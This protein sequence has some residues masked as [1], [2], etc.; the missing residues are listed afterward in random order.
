VNTASSEHQP[1]KEVIM[2]RKLDNI[3]KAFAIVAH[4]PISAVTSATIRTIS[5]PFRA[6][7]QS[8]STYY[9]QNRE[10]SLKYQR[11][12][13]AV[14]ECDKCDAKDYGILSK[15]HKQGD[16]KE[17]SRPIARGENSPTTYYGKNTFCDEHKQ[18]ATTAQS[19][20]RNA[21][22]Y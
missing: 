11:I 15:W 12:N 16:I 20:Y 9:A 14:K 8:F 2:S 7:R 13:I 17:H 18:D 22:D 6:K 3:D 10:E 5:N 1:K 19:N 4:N 21:R